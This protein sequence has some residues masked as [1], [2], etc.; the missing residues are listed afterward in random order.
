MKLNNK[1]I[2]ICLTCILACSLFIGCGNNKATTAKKT[3]AK[4][5][6]STV[7]H[8]DQGIRDLTNK[9][10]GLVY[11]VNANNV[12][13]NFAEANK[14]YSTKSDVNGLFRG[15]ATKIANDIKSKNETIKFNEIDF[16]EIKYTELVNNTTKHDYGFGAIVPFKVKYTEGINKID[17]DNL[18]VYYEN[19]MW[20]VI[21][22]STVEEK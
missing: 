20:E 12:D 21:D 8:D 19:N 10:V 14:L 3:P 22:F 18:F 1:I 4:Q 11:N 17:D 15:D 13:S 6:I 9:F 16:G 2:T 5:Q 7:K